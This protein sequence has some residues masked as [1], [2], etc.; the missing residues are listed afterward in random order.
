[1]HC[2]FP[3]FQSRKMS[4]SYSCVF[5]QRDITH[6][7]S[8]SIS[9]TGLKASWVFSLLFLW[10]TLGSALHMCLP[11]KYRYSPLQLLGVIIMFRMWNQKHL[12]QI[13]CWQ[14]ADDN[15]YC[16]WNK[17]KQKLCHICIQYMTPCV[18]VEAFSVFS[19]VIHRCRMVKGHCGILCI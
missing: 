13:R 6:G 8:S 18:V 16:Q 4:P 14:R 2:N 5:L 1:M 11:H 17:A 15:I 12:F 9:K 3:V 7:H 19:V 10:T